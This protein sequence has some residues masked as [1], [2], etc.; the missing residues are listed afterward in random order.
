MSYYYFNPKISTNPAI[1]LPTDAVYRKPPVVHKPSSSP[2]KQTPAL[3]QPSNDG[4]VLSGAAAATAGALSTTLPSSKLSPTTTDNDNCYNIHGHGSN[5]QVSSP[6]NWS[7]FSI[8]NSG[9]HGLELT[10]S[11]SERSGPSSASFTPSSNIISR[12]DSSHP[13]IQPLQ[14]QQRSPLSNSWLQ[15]LSLDKEWVIFSP[16]E[17]S[18]EDH[19][20]SS[21]DLDDENENEIRPTALSFPG[22]NGSGSF[23][24][25]L[26][27]SISSSA[28]VAAATTSST[29][30][31][32]ATVDR[33]NAWRINQS[34]HILLQFK[35]LERTRRESEVSNGS[36]N[37]T[38]LVSSEIS[39]WGLPE[40]EE[41]DED[42]IAQSHE[43]I[44]AALSSTSS[45]SPTSQS[46][47]A[48][49][50]S[51]I[52][53]DFHQILNSSAPYQAAIR[54]LA[55]ATENA[56]NKQ[57]QQALDH[58]L[59]AILDPSVSLTG[60]SSST[61]PAETASAATVESVK[62]RIGSNEL[63]ARHSILWDFI[64]QTVLYN[65]FIGVNDKLL[66]V[67]MG[68]QFLGSHIKNT[69]SDISSSQHY[70]GYGNYL[71]HTSSSIASVPRYSRQTCSEI[72]DAAAKAS[73]R[74]ILYPEFR[75]SSSSSSSS[76]P[77]YG[78][79]CYTKSAT[80]VVDFMRTS[81]RLRLGVPAASPP[82]NIPVTASSTASSIKAL[83]AGVSPNALVLL[84]FLRSRLFAPFYGTKETV[85]NNK[86]AS[87]VSSSSST[88]TA[89]HN[90]NHVEETPNNYWEVSPSST[91]GTA[92]ECGQLIGVW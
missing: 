15:S 2:V 65:N 73:V 55:T 53:Q 56:Q 66:Q 23:L 40:E 24:D 45:I 69:G 9:N 61:E 18:E 82:S 39:S 72:L 83:H 37:T 32:S 8:E 14:Q 57:Q 27:R 71:S 70:T 84:D 67:I 17:G 59:N 90:A 13:S 52:L 36:G 12:I 16:E 33:I 88:D 46:T 91:T 31:S 54:L 86:N 89:L 58:A 48:S 78:R 77:L 7:P 42:Y 68:E 28:I 43:E 4:Q 5:E 29:T 44:A 62:S 22:H 85:M 75:S 10:E 3:Q 87:S 34:Q 74:H 35:K 47:S 1:P 60:S 26:N 76:S 30:L 80:S 11:S 81:Q 25:L 79:G 64:T 49:L 19:D 20:S 51:L 6:T 38:N 41:E 21:N 63:R 92:S 50:A